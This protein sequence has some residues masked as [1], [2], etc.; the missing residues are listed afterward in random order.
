[1]KGTSEDYR[2]RGRVVEGDASWVLRNAP[3]SAP[4]LAGHRPVE[5]A[6]TYGTR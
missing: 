1:M 6:S 5:L 2:I 4:P 3:V